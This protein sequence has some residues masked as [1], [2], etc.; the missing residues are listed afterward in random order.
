M[1]PVLEHFLDH[2]Y[3]ATDLHRRLRLLRVVLEEVLYDEPHQLRVL[4]AKERRAKA[5][6]ASVPEIDQEVF[7]TLTE[8]LWSV[9]T[10]ATL[11]SKMGA[12]IEEAKLLPVMTLYIPVPFTAAQL[13]PLVRWAR[14]RVAPGMLFEVE[15]EPKVVGGCAFVYKD[16]HYDWSLRRYLRAKRGLVTSLLNTYGHVD[17]PKSRSSEKI[18]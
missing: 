4:P 3:E 17:T 13:M 8:E 5:V 14:A 11:S 7:D 10:G 9:F 2:T 1:S 16:V 15:V 6:K 18:A 12:V